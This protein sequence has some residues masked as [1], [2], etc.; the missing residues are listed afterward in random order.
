MQEL[1]TKGREYETDAS[2][3]TEL[4]HYTEY[5]LYANTEMIVSSI[6][7]SDTTHPFNN[8]MIRQDPMLG[9]VF[10]YISNT[11]VSCSAHDLEAGAWNIVLR[12]DVGAGKTTTRVRTIHT[13]ALILY[14]DTLYLFVA[15]LDREKN[16]FLYKRSSRRRSIRRSEPF[17]STVSRLFVN[18]LRRIV[19]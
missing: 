4:F 8:S 14:S 10:E 1:T 16:H 13:S 7:L 2:V 5:V 15:S 17:T 3:V 11:P 9:Q 18:L 12:F 6:N 19:S